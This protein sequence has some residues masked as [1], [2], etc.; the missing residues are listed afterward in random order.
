LKYSFL[1]R[2]TSLRS[3]YRVSCVLGHCSRNLKVEATMIP[4]RDLN[5]SRGTPVITYGII[6]ICV[7][8]FFYELT[9]GRQ[10][11]SFLLEYGLTPIRYSNPQIAVRFSFPEQALPFVTSMFLHGGWMHLIGNMWVLYIFGDNVEDYL[12]HERYLLFYLLC[13]VSAGAIHLL[14]NLDSSLP[15]VGAS[16]AIG[17]VMGAYFIL[18]PRARILTLLPIFFFFTFIEVPAYVF[19]GFWFLL[20]FFSGTVGSL[21]GGGGSGGIAWWAHVGGFGAGVLFLKWFGPSKKQMRFDGR[22]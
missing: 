21:A 14:T 19:L 9:Q 18:Y 13:G 15:T 2:W 5:P 3:E 8:T 16:G 1:W 6:A 7:L 12:G 20:Q 17:G 11:H 22:E 4:I 10:L